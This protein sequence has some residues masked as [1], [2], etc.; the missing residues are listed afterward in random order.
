M[1]GWCQGDPIG[2]RRFAT[3]FVDQPLRLECGELF[4]PI[5]LAYESWGELNHTRSNAIL[6]LHGF[7]GDSHAAGPAEPGHPQ[8]GWWDEL[9][10]PGRPL[11]T[12]EFFILCPNAFG[13]CQGSTGPGSLA[14]DGHRYGS[15]FPTITIRDLVATEMALAEQL[16]IQTWHA[17]LGGSMGGMRALEWAITRPQAVDRLLVM[18]T[19]AYATAEQIALHHAQIRAIELDPQFQATPG[20]PDP[21]REPRDGLRLARSMAILSYGYEREFAGLFHRRPE[22]DND[23]LSQGRYAIEAYL[24]EQGALLADHFDAYSYITLT[25]AMSHHDVGRGRGSV[26]EAL[27]QIRA[28][29]RI[30]SVSTDRLFPPRLQ[31]E[32]AQSLRSGVTFTT[33]DSNH[34]HDGFLWEVRQLAP[35]IREML[36]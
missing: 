29:V 10:G 1:A 8:R 17:V 31:L 4:G 23:P 5:T 24:D 3:L 28:R 22:A 30:V 12:N 9:I 11:D 25:R 6:L 18:A 36:G 21:S 35:V 26:E 34:G 2:Q 19:T 33:I 14:P 20:D 13:G 32:I 27:A 7:T 15:R 16:G